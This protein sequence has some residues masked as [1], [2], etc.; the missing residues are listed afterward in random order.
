MCVPPVA[1]RRARAACTCTHKV[2]GQSVRSKL[3]YERGAVDVHLL[4]R[5]CHNGGS[6]YKGKSSK[7]GLLKRATKR[8]E[9]ARSRSSSPLET[10][11]ISPLSLFYSYVNIDWQRVLLR[12]KHTFPMIFTSSAGKW[13]LKELPR[14]PLSIQKHLRHFFRLT[15]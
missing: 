6:D 2:R 3:T 1:R 9:E 15:G 12:S 4:H 10:F 7:R 14:N 11:N 5:T 8:G 13:I